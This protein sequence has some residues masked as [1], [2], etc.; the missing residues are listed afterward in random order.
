MEE[1]VQ[2]PMQPG[3]GASTLVIPYTLDGSKSKL[4]QLRVRLWLSIPI[5]L[6]CVAISIGLALRAG[7]LWGIVVFFLAITSFWVLIR[8]VV[9]QEFSYYKDYR[10]VLS[11]DLKVDTPDFWRIYSI[12]DDKPHIVRF[13]NG[14]I[15]MF[16]ALEPGIVV[17]KGLPEEEKHY[18][19]IAE[20]LNRAAN[21]KLDLVRI[22]YMGQIGKDERIDDKVREISNYTNTDL[23]DLMLTN[24]TH[25]KGELQESFSTFDVILFTSNDDE[26]TFEDKVYEV[27]SIFMEANYDRFVVMGKREIRDLVLTLMNI[28]EFSVQKANFESYSATSAGITPIRLYDENGVLIE[29]FNKTTA[30]KKSESVNR[31]KRSAAIEKEKKRRKEELKKSKKRRKVSTTED[32]E[33]T[34]ELDLFG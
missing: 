29:E 4:N 11:N 24:Y 12:T 20:A 25:L 13:Q 31:T 15:G 9:L 26:Y 6:V 21:I 23:R 33:E 18:N 5:S 2:H 10:D 32:V 22:D 1:Q 19:K 16:V 14:L 27:M 28:E 30:E 34:V 8:F 17:G 3:Y 7:G